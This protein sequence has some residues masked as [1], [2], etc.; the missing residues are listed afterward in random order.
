MDTKAADLAAKAKL[1]EKAIEWLIKEDILTCE[2]VALLA[3]NEEQAD[4]NFIDTMVGAG[5]GI[6]LGAWVGAGVGAGD[7]P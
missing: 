4:K 5:V 1:N 3:A 7:G 6:W 2:D